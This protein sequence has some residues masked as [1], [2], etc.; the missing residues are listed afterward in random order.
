MSTATAFRHHRPFPF[1][2]ESG[3]FPASFDYVD[4]SLSDAMALWW[5]LEAV[6]FVTAGS[7][8]GAT[9]N[10]TNTIGPT[11]SLGFT[12]TTLVKGGSYYGSGTA[13]ALAPRLRVCQGASILSITFFD[14]ATPRTIFT[15]L[16]SI[17][18]SGNPALPIRIYYLFSILS[19]N[20]N[21]PLGKESIVVSNP[22]RVSSYV[23][24]PASSGTLIFGAASL[25]WV[26]GGYQ[27]NPAGTINTWTGE[28]AT[29]SLTTGFFTY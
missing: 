28:P 5:N 9:I 10:F 7:K 19:E 14:T 12:P 1:C 21:P 29:A 22:A 2:P 13:P 17:K 11:Q 27:V 26:G 23:G 8:G 18:D 6:E 16:S 25:S 24:T 3:S 20:P 15:F 4:V